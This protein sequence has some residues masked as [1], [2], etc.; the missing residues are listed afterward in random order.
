MFI[1]T[2]VT[3]TRSLSNIKRGD[4]HIYRPQGVRL[5]PIICFLPS[6]FSHASVFFCDRLVL[7]GKYCSQVESSIAC[8]DDICKNREDVR[9]MLEVRCSEYVFLKHEF[10]HYFE[11]RAM[12]L[13]CELSFGSRSCLFMCC[14]TPPPGG[15]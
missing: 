11:I 10:K 8:L 6:I 12:F 9:Q 7:Y 14:K 1:I 5:S 4:R 3:C 13:S 2:P 15:C